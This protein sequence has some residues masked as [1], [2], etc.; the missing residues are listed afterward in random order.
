M[1]HHVHSASWNIWSCKVDVWFLEGNVWISFTAGTDASTMVFA[2]V[3]Y[4]EIALIHS[5]SRSYA[6]LWQWSFWDFSVSMDTINCS[7]FLLWESSVKVDFEWRQL[8]VAVALCALYHCIEADEDAG[9]FHTCNKCIWSKHTELTW[10]TWMST[11][12]PHRPMWVRKVNLFY[13]KSLIA[14]QLYS[15]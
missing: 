10:G 2:G 3:E 11:L 12:K 5:W 6:C 9:H 1:K 4:C 15:K 8:E 7:P 14:L 13:V